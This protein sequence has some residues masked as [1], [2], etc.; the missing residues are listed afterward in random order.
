MS[1]STII[2]HPPAVVFTVATDPHLQLR[3]DANTL[4]HVEQLTADPAGVGT[5]YR[6]HA[7]GSGVTEYEVVEYEPG[8]RFTQCSV[9]GIG[10]IRHSFV[11]EAVPEGTRLVQQVDLQPTFWGLLLQPWVARRVQQRLREIAAGISQYLLAH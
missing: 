9:L 3:W 10:H 11:F 7:K 1:E 4:T 8:Q 2:A 5:R 6:G